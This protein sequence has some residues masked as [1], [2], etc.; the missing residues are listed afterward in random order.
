[1]LILTALTALTLA[2]D[3]D[4]DWD[5][6]APPGPA[7]TVSI[8]TTTGTW[9]SVDVSPDGETLVFDLLGDLY[10]MPIAGGEATSLT[11]GM[12]WDMQPTFSPDGR[13]IAFTSDRG[14]GDNIWT[15]ALEDEALMQL[16]KESF[17]LLNSPTWTPDGRGVVARK[18]FTSGRSLGSGE[19]WLYP[20]TGGNGLQLT[21]KPNE[22]M[23]VGEPVLSPDGRWLYYSHDASGG[24][25]FQY[26]KDPNAG[27]YAIDRL[28]RV[29]GEIERVTGGAGG[30]V[31]PTP[32]P[33]GQ[34]LAFVRRIRGKSVLM[35]R[36]LTSGLEHSLWHGLDR[37]MQET[38]AIHGVYPAFSWTPDGDSLVI[39]A[40]GGLHRV[41][42]D[43]SVHAIPFHV[44]STREVR[45]A[46]RHAVDLA[47]EERHTRALRWVSTSPDGSLVAYQALGKIWLRNLPDGEPRRL[48]KQSDHDEFYPSFS[49]DGQRIVFTTWH[50]QALG[51]VRVAKTKSGKAR[52]ITEEP[53]HYITPAFSSDG[54]TVLV[55][56][57][58]GGWLRSPTWS[59]N[60]GL[61]AVD[62]AGGPLRLL[63][64]HGSLPR[65]STDGDL[66]YL[67]R[68]GDDGVELW[69][70]HTTTRE[71][72]NVAGCEMCTAVTVSPDGQWLAFQQHYN[73]YVTPMVD[74]GRTR[75]LGG[76]D[77]AMPVVKASADVGDFLHFSGDSSRLHWSTGPEL[78]TLELAPSFAKL[79]ADK[80]AKSDADD[81]EEGDSREE[82]TEQDEEEE[83]AVAGVD[84]GFDFPLARPGGAVA[85]VG[86]RVVTMRGDEVIEDG[87]VLWR[88]DMI[89]AVGPRN[90]VIV[91]ADAQRV[92]GTGKTVIP[93]LIDVHAHGGFGGQGLIPE[94]NWQQ[95]ANLALGVTTIHDPSNDTHTVFAASEL[96]AAG[97]LLAPRITSTGTI[98]YGAKGPGYTAK[99][100]GLDDARSH[101][102]RLQAIG[103]FSVKSYNQP[104]RDQ[105]QQI[106][107]AAREL[108]MMV[109]PEGGSLFMHNMTHVVDG[110]TGVEHAIPVA[111]AYDDVLQLWSAT[112][113]GYTPTL[114]VAYGGL[115]GEVYWYGRTDVWNHPRLNAFVPPFALDPKA[116]RATVSHDDDYNHIDAARFAKALV[117]AGGRVQV[118]AHGQREGLAAHWEMWMLEQGGMTA[119]EALRAGTLFGAAYLGLDGSVGSIEVGKLADMVVIDGNPLEDLRL[120]DQVALTIL[121]G[122]VYDAATM[123]SV[124]PAGEPRAP[125]FF[126]QGEGEGQA[127]D[128]GPACGCGVH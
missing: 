81:Q 19:M 14:G 16:S 104:R 3:N 74:T 119:H 55:H 92:D 103:A 8:D 58:G 114:G 38:W 34:T 40:Q 108:G 98:L 52:T 15:L 70:M 44:A 22:Q 111:K 124:A 106:L 118:G 7:E 9:M 45:T 107:E 117:D 87:T 97:H 26:N 71:E 80:A 93:G 112:E 60:R 67:T 90:E 105:R 73:A 20:L 35:L 48:T 49:A 65:P 99:V 31:R 39:W 110:H 127:P 51:S 125:L 24:S 96:A 82:E 123:T 28:D 56:K 101:L 115:S 122:Q 41:S 1:V 64:K 18:H 94:Q 37:D 33:D 13:S 43:G 79:A 116:R 11:E 109:V 89:V 46:V 2:A 66:I 75:S 69:Q 113:V 121:G 36:D 85:L 42:L 5:V 68:H 62:A 126:E 23:D 78:F 30:A 32:S 102:K 72:R 100:D 57:V 47:P 25:H 95:L 76:E 12:A 88:R 10:T 53:G 50:D 63:T 84:I 6:N 4:Q 120:S 77:G 61:H 21:E 128:A 17:R 59:A 86:A 29:S 83:E 54:E 27:I 91:P